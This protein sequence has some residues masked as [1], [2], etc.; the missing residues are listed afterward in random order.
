MV[1]I[2]FIDYCPDYTLFMFDPV[3]GVRQHVFCEDRFCPETLWLGIL[4]IA[5]LAQPAG[6][7]YISVID[8]GIGWA[9]VVPVYECVRLVHSAPLA[10]PEFIR[11]I[12]STS[13]IEF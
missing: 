1:A 8:E 4:I 11:L 7:S 10:Y 2:A 5:L 9:A 6:G 12:A 13:C 3:G